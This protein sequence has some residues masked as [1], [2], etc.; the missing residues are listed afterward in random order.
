M[1]HYHRFQGQHLSKRWSDDIEAI[2]YFRQAESHETADK[3]AERICGFYYRISNYADASLLSVEIV[4]RD[5]PPAPWWAL[6]RYG[7]CQLTLGSPTNALAAFERALPLAPTEEDRGT[8]LNNLSQIYD[9]RGDYDTAL[10]YLDQSLQIQREIGDKAG[11]IP[12]LHNMAYIALQ[13]DDQ[14]RAMDLWS[15]AL[16]LALETK[17]AQGIFHVA[18]TLGT[19]MAQSG[20]HDQAQQLLQMAVDVGKQA[21]FPGVEQVEATLSQLQAKTA[22]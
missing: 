16:T 6:N 10:R 21:G 12:T 2:Y 5:A 11:L 13:A 1:G 7:M 8:T 18:S 20:A 3:L 17:N 14:K 22:K 4:E 9:A 15:E 19:L